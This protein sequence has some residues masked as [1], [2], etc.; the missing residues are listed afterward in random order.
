MGNSPLSQLGVEKNHSLTK[1]IGH[2][3]KIVA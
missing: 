3:A 1:N 2:N